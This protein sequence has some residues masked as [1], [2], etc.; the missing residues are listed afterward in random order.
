[1]ERASSLSA[2]TSPSVYLS[3]PEQDFSC[4]SKTQKVALAIIVS[5]ASFF[6]LPAPLPIIVSL[7]SLAGIVYV[8]TRSS[9]TEEA[10][11]NERPPSPV[12]NRSTLEFDFSSPAKNPYGRS[13]ESDF[14]PFGSLLDEPWLPTNDSSSYSSSSSS[15]NS[16]LSR[17]RRRNR[18]EDSLAPKVGVKK[19]PYQSQKQLKFPIDQHSFPHSSSEFDLRRQDERNAAFE[20]EFLSHRQV[21]N[22]SSSERHSPLKNERSSNSVLPSVGAKQSPYKVISESQPPT[23][24]GCPVID[25]D[26]SD[27]HIQV[28]SSVM[29]FSA[30]TGSSLL[31]LV[32]NPPSDDSNVFEKPFPEVHRQVGPSDSPVSFSPLKR[33]KPSYSVLPSVGAK[34][35]SYEAIPQGQ[36]HLSPPVQLGATVASNPRAS[37]VKHPPSNDHRQL[38]SQVSSAK[39]PISPARPSVGTKL[40][41]HE[42]VSLGQSNSIAPSATFLPTHAT[43]RTPV[44]PKS[45][46]PSNPLPTPPSSVKPG[47]G[48]K[49]SPHEQP[50]TPMSGPSIAVPTVL[51][52]Q[53]AAS[54][55]PVGGAPPSSQVPSQAPRRQVGG[56]S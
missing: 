47:D 31:D 26:E 4:A 28:G 20:K 45:S 22:V 10:L 19:S 8:L 15:S 32:G 38:G 40:N 17:S 29:S 34:Q 36:M 23:I 33:E 56:G 53:N 21:G 55:R 27:G 18:E 51:P 14:K 43:Q 3:E 52:S 6:F 1:M 39:S 13:L 25:G 50:P 30:Y 2:K 9:K 5:C 48:R 16:S 41:P 54:H 44:P 11:L 37:V 49:A 42:P 12:I 7:I 24:L 35:S 46:L